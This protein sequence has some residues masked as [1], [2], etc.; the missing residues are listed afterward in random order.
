MFI[1]VT[2]L[3]R[4]LVT[5]CALAV[6]LVATG[7]SVAAD[8]VTMTVVHQFDGSPGS[9]EGAQPGTIVFG[10]DRSLYG[11]TLNGG[12][13]GAGTIFKIGADGRFST[14]YTFKGP[15][16]NW[17]NPCL[18]PGAD[19]NFY[20]TVGENSNKVRVFSITPAGTFT[21]LA[22]FFTELGPQDQRSMIVRAT[23]G[24]RYAIASYGITS[25]VLVQQTAA[26]R[27]SPAYQLLSW[28]SAHRR[29]PRAA[30][31]CK[32]CRQWHAE[33]RKRQGCGNS[34][35]RRMALCG[36]IAP[37]ADGHFWKA[38]LIRDSNSWGPP[39]RSVSTNIRDGFHPAIPMYKP[40]SAAPGTPTQN[41]DWQAA[42]GV[43]GRLAEDDNGVMLA[44]AGEHEIIGISRF[45]EIS[46][47]IPLAPLGDK[48]YATMGLMRA[49]DGYFYGLALAGDYN[50]YV[51]IYRTSAEGPP[52]AVYRF[53]QSGPRETIRSPIV[54]GPDG[55]LYVTTI[56]GGKDRRGAIYR[57]KTLP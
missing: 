13:Y 40:P 53:P 12:L 17:P 11:T 34:A 42:S 56:D 37:A 2:C 32:P 57:V 30:K 23:D 46:R 9:N 55:S 43:S 54:E 49:R 26:A 8:T 24:Q 41:P 7:N 44:M 45:A 27:G 25:F 4:G 19:G 38:S 48:T 28:H 20:G 18:L 51:L 1:K 14:I 22:V 52:K 10:S 50:G 6:S 31:L 29:W 5:C 33:W 15:D 39:A 3:R 36:D 21:L 47:H 35:G 16:G